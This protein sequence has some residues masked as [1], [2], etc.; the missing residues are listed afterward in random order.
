VFKLLGAGALVLAALS[1]RTIARATGSAWANATTLAVGLNPVLLLEG[2]ASGHNDVVMMSLMLAG[3]ACQ[4]KGRTQAGYLLL[5]CSAGVKYVTATIVPWLLLRERLSLRSSLR[6]VAVASALVLI[7]NVASLAV[8]WRGAHTF[9]GLRDVYVQRT[10][11]SETPNRSPGSTAGGNSKG[12]AQAARRSPLSTWLRLSALTL[13]YAA[14]TVMVARAGI[15][16]VLAAWAAFALAVVWVGMPVIFA[17]YMAWPIAPAMARPQE[18]RRVAF[19]S[20]V[21]GAVLQF[22]YTVPVLG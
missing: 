14:L 9:D 6:T 8:F 17:W 15:P 13:V 19:A 4:L 2:P 18:L 22:V 7:P 5:G 10:D 1:A 16:R 11:A 12:R 21:S 3:I 20:L